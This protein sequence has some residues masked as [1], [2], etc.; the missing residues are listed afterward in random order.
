MALLSDG[1]VAAIESSI[2]LTSAGCSTALRSKV[3]TRANAA[4]MTIGPPFDAGAGS[5]MNGLT[6]TAATLPPRIIFA[7][8]T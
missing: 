3:A 7:R 8:V 2:P 6:S 5:R 1:D 4:G